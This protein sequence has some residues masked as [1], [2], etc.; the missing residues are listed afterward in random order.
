MRGLAKK[1]LR[2][3]R[4]QSLV[5]FALI[6]PMFLVIM[7]LITEFGRALFQYNVLVS[8]TR[9]GARAGVIVSEGSAPGQAQ[10]FADSILTAAHIPLGSVTLNAVV[11]DNYGGSNI[12]V[13]RVTADKQF[14]WLYK[15]GLTMQGGATVA[16]P[17]G[18]Q[19]HAETIMKGEA[20]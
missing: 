15:G 17:G 12:K 2:G 11:E 7:F 6:L 14:D 20:F 1:F 9:A 19:L 16:K 3:A 10:Q 13:L 8:A 4:G 5:E 18:L